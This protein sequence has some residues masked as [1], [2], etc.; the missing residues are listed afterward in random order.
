VKG[1]Y[2]QA[3]LLIATPTDFSSISLSSHTLQKEV[4][5][6]VAGT[7]KAAAEGDERPAAQEQLPPAPILNGASGPKLHETELPNTQ[8]AT[9][10]PVAEGGS[11]TLPLTPS[12][13]PAHAL[14]QGREQLPMG[15]GSLTGNAVAA[16]SSGEGLNPLP[17]TA[18]AAQSG[19]S[20]AVPPIL[21]KPGSGGGKSSTAERLRS[22]RGAGNL[23]SLQPA[24]ALAQG[25]SSGP[26]ADASAMMR[27][28]AGVRSSMGATGELAAGTTTGPDPRETFTTLDAAD[29]PGR[30]TWIH[31]GAQ[32]AEAGFQDPTLGWVGVRAD[33]G[34]GGVHAELVAGSADAAQALG[35]HLAG[36]N[37]YLAEHHTPVE[38]LTLSAP[39][40]GWAGL[41]SD[42]GA[43]EGMQQGTGHPS[44][45]ETAQGADASSS[46]GRPEG[47]TIVPAA[48]P[49][50][51]GLFA[52]LDGSAPAA[53]PG[54]VHIS[55]M[56]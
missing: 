17:V 3:N 39:D 15:P 5:G 10:L 28:A 48:V 38:T 37:A 6:E 36:L 32:Q 1:G 18:G 42:K 26:A 34:G 51:P 23:D 54:G 25:P 8:E 45:Q 40:G 20:V 24:R 2:A 13:N 29:A 7:A 30:P 52:G 21:D 46:S 53:R 49:E 47:R 11:A 14:A 22:A 27:E 41:G 43:G 31:A 55:V 4:S 16:S 44:G 50:L 9:P 56:A 19:E 33:M 35:S 12:Q